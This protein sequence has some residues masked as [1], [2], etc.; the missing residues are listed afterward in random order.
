MHLFHASQIGLQRILVRCI[1]VRYLGVSTF[2]VLNTFVS[3]E[4]VCFTVNS[5]RMSWFII[6]YKYKTVL[7]SST[8]SI[9]WN[10]YPSHNYSHSFNKNQNTMYAC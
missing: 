1:L 10:I 5:I 8:W 7:S 4:I 3:R 6:I 9:N 2:F